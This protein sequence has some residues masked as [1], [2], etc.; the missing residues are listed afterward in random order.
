MLYKLQWGEDSLQVPLVLTHFGVHIHDV[1]IGLFSENLA[2]Q[3]GNFWGNFLEYEVSN[4][5]KENR[6]FMRIKAQIDIRHPLKRKKQI[7][8]GG[9]CSYVTFKYE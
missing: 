8:F 4:L 6:N 1:P 2:M 3:L 7:L 9:R 5:G